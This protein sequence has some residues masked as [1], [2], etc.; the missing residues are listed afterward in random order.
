MLYYGILNGIIVFVL[1]TL[2]IG[3]NISIIREPLKYAG[4]VNGIIV[5]TLLIVSIMMGYLIEGPKL[6]T[7]LKYIPLP[8]EYF[9]LILIILLFNLAVFNFLKIPYSLT[10][11]LIGGL[12][13][14][15]F[16]N[17]IAFDKKYL[18][19]LV[20]IWI[21]Y[22]L[23]NIIFAKYLYSF[24]KRQ[25][26]SNISLTRV[27]GLCSSFFIG[28][29]FGSNTIGALTSLSSNDSLTNLALISI[30]TVLGIIFIGRGTGEILAGKL[31]GLR[32][33]MFISTTLSTSTL[34]EIATQ[35]SIPIPL[36]SLSTLGYLGPAYATG[37]RIL[38]YK[39]IRKT[40]VFWILNPIVTF[41]FTFSIFWVSRF[42]GF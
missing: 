14:F 2:I 32:P 25:E 6:Y 4:I 20:M 13:G 8:N 12:I 31:Y 17:S 26:W 3:N 41:S 37:S 40:L 33:Y 22:P 7:I 39:E 35:L 11:G 34:I 10:Q 29:T 19:I 23:L 38:R 5:D 1:A 30:S 9:S 27:I 36:S 15:A 42:F 18:V 21:L 24:L 28:Y 16:F